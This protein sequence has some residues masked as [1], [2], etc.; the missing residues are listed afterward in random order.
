MNKSRPT[1]P[2]LLLGLIVGVVVVVVAGLGWWWPTY[3][4]LAFERAEWDA[5]EAES[6][7]NDFR[8][9]RMADT[10]MWSRTL[11]GKTKAEVIAILGEP[12][13]HFNRERELT[14]MLGSTRFFLP[15]YADLLSI[16]LNEDGRVS[17][18]WIFHD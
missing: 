9:H 2:R 15:I 8:R 11:H 17:E 12:A 6:K 14:Y 4:S 16:Q 1:R 18:V 3:G 13:D 7:E 5:A 10:L